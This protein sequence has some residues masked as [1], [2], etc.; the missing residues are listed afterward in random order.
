MSTIQEQYTITPKGNIL[1]FYDALNEKKYNIAFGYLSP[2]L[3]KRVWGN[4]AAKFAKGYFF[5][6]ELTDFDPK[7]TENE[8]TY[9]FSYTDRIEELQHPLITNLAEVQATAPDQAKQNITLFKESLIK[10]FAADPKKV[11][12]LED[13]I[14]FG[15]NAVEVALYKTDGSYEKAD[16]ILAKVE[17]TTTQTR[18]ITCVEK[19][20][21]FQISAIKT[22]KPK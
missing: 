13:I 2:E 10:D 15:H 11:A 21:G 1:A 6:Q 9:N 3:R 16:E 14:L 20:Q 4:D 12:E 7:L 19:P 5:T 22:S 18:E 8:H 17:K